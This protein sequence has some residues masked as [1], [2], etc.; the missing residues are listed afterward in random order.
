[1]AMTWWRQPADKARPHV[2]RMALLAALL[3]GVPA[4]AWAV[5][6]DLGKLRAE[7]KR[8]TS[9]PFP[10]DNPY[11]DLKSKLGELL[12]WDPRLSGENNISC[13]TCHTPS[14]AWSDPL[15]LSIGA[16]GKPMPKRS[17]TLLNLAWTDLTMWDGRFPTLESQILG[18]LFNKDI[19]SSDRKAMP[20]E[21]AAIPAYK[22]LFEQVFPGEPVSGET[23]AK[24]IATYERTLVSNKAPFDRWVDGDDK[25]LDDRAKRGLALF[26]GKANCAACHNTWRFTDDGFHDIG[27]NDDDP[28]RGKHVPG[29]EVLERAF[30]TPTLRNVAQRPPYMHNGEIASLEE[31]VRH[32]ASGFL[33]R[34]SLSP[35]MKRLNLSDDEI[36]DLIAFMHALTS[37]DDPIPTPVL[38]VKEAM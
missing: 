10:K 8:P 11:T 16:G 27:L 24:A 21:I 38:P 28:G 6:A 33:E 1:M 9:I 12:F 4:H 26:V 3:L 17:Q 23:I 29:V 35:E 2:R 19:M 20:E 14:F 32:Y 18:P 22:K 30:K 31:V 5:D 34:P 37:E 13:A 7:Y 36:K 25:A 15:K